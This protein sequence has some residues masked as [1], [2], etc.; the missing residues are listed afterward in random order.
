M[1]YLLILFAIVILLWLRVMSV[2][3]PKKDVDV[4]LEPPDFSLWF[5][6]LGFCVVTIMLIT[7][8]WLLA[9]YAPI[10]GQFFNL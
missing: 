8:F 7:T 1:A 5:D 4:T 9:T 6:T 2:H 3:S 10:F